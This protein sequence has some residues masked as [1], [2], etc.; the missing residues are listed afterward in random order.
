MKKPFKLGRYAAM[1]QAMLEYGLPLRTVMC[2]ELF[3]GKFY[4]T[5]KTK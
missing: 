2:G 3:N 1:R 5:F 4:L